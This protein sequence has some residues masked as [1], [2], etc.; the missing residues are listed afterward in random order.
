M[1]VQLMLHSVSQQQE[2]EKL[3][4]L[5][6][7]M[8]KTTCSK[9]SFHTKSIVLTHRFGHQQSQLRAYAT[10][11]ENG[12]IAIVGGG[13]GGL[14]AARVLQKHG[15]NPVVFEREPSRQARGQGGQLDLHPKSGR[16][17][18]KQILLAALA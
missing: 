15:F 17:P 6:L 4:P 7:Q 3:L 1:N 13:L 12:Q 9:K 11:N 2:V 10:N 5:A 18:R 14:M 8:A 16:L